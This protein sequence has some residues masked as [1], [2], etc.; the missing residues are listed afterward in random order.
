MSRLWIGIVFASAQWAGLGLGRAETWKILG[1]RPMGM[2]GAFVAMA[3]GGIAQYWNPAG[4][5]QEAAVS[6]WGLQ[7][8]VG[9][10]GEFT[11][12]VLK[13]ANALSDLASQYD[14]IQAAQTSGTAGA[15]DATKVG[16]FYQG[17][18]TIKNMN[19]PGKGALGEIAG[20]ANFKAGRFAMSVNNFTSVGASP[21]IDTT[22]IGLDNSGSLSGVNFATANTAAPGDATNAASAA[23]INSAIDATAFT[24]LN[25]LMGGELTTAGITE[26]NIGNALVNFANGNGASTAQIAEAAAQISNNIGAVDP[27]IAAAS[28]ANP[29][30][31]NGTNLTVRGGSFTEVAFGYA[32]PV[33]LPG[34]YAGGNLKLIFG[35]VGYTRFNVLENGSGSTN[36]LKKF[37]DNTASSVAPGVDLGVLWHL[38]EVLPI[39]PFKPRA[40]LVWR[41]INSPGFK[42]P[43]AATADGDSSNYPQDGQARMGLAVTPLNFWNVALDLDLTQNNTPVPGYHSRQLGLGTE[44]NVFNRSWINIPLRAGLMKNLADS[45]S[46]LAYT[47]GFGL[48]FLHFML[49]VGGAVSSDRTQIKSGENI[50]SNF[51]A[52]AQLG[53]MF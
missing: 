7:I 2:G 14:A 12:G 10:R 1:P 19:Q 33:L 51:A 28:G 37:R 27:L 41:N 36:V 40:G 47:F 46:K 5:A 20:G 29:Y 15:M 45:S 30:T 4:L 32:R 44:V 17:L 43:G 11:G 49:D 24:N 42:Q 38:R 9:A 48:N 18:A 25:N 16:A 3:E 23:S 31:N 52:A 35:R 26:A 39:L 6:K 13:D 50:P 53:F 8:P 21:F 34:L 22:N